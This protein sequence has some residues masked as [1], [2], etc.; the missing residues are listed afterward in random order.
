MKGEKERKGMVNSEREEKEKIKIRKRIGHW[1]GN[2]R[3]KKGKG[4]MERISI[5]PFPLLFLFPLLFPFISFWNS[6]E[7]KPSNIYEILE[8]INHF[9][10]FEEFP[11][12]WQDKM[13]HLTPF[14]FFLSL[15]HICTFYN[16]TYIFYKYHLLYYCSILHLKAQNITV[17]KTNGHRNTFPYPQESVE[18]SVDRAFHHDHHSVACSKHTHTHTYEDL[19]IMCLFNASAERERTGW[20]R[21]EKTLSLKSKCYVRDNIQSDRNCGQIGRYLEWWNNRC[22]EP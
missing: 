13:L 11:F 18:G 21:A 17:S 2:E 5:S 4:E 20:G 9:R 7:L 19:R 6:S 16:V 3:E 1:K 10:S 8:E 22:L 14:V 15:N 12:V